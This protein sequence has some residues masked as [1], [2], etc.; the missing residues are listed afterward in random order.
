MSTTTS[1]ARIQAFTAAANA[2]INCAQDSPSRLVNERQAYYGAAGEC[3]SEARDLKKAG[4][5]YRRAEKYTA[6]ARAYEEG[7]Y[8]DEM[9]EIIIRHGGALNGSLLERLKMVARM[10]YFKVYL[11]GWLVSESH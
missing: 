1:I 5:S 11:N 3:Y 9:T 7:E 4:D 10:H 6:A 8:F 2:F